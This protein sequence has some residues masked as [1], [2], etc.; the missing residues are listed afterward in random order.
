MQDWQSFTDMPVTDF[1]FELLYYSD[2]YVTF[3]QVEKYPIKNKIHT[4]KN[5]DSETTVKGI[6]QPYIT[7]KLFY[8]NINNDASIPKCW[9]F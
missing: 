8:A 7:H 9:E 3:A 4:W 2:S 6:F 5:I 1:H